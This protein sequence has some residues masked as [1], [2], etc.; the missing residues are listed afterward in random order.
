MLKA[1]EI[2]ARAV[3]NTQLIIAGTDHPKT[4]G[5]LESIRQKCWRHPRIKFMGYV[6]EEQ[7]PELFQSTTVT[8]MPY[9][10]SGVQ[11]RSTFGLRLW[12]TDGGFRYFRLS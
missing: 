9:T 10:S 6:P 7:I 3:P 2:V 8:V 4:P 11:R 12:C 1:F 5:Y